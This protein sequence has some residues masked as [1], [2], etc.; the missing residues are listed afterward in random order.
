VVDQH[1]HAGNELEHPS[2]RGIPVGP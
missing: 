2:P 1:E